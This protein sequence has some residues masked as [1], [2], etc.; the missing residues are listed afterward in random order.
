MIFITIDCPPLRI[1]TL[2]SALQISLLSLKILKYFNRLPNS[3][4]TYISLAF[5][6]NLLERTSIL[7]RVVGSLPIQS[8]TY[9]FHHHFFKLVLPKFL[10]DSLGLQISCNIHGLLPVSNRDNHCPHSRNT[11]P[12]VSVMSFTSSFLHLCINTSS[13]LP[14]LFHTFLLGY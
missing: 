14:V 8:L 5:D 3:L 12:L 4:G 11:F 6:I 10:K 7:S 9:S 13:Q 2:P 1:S